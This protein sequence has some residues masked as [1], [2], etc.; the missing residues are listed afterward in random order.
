MPYAHRYKT[1]SI[2]ICSPRIYGQRTVSSALTPG[3][4]AGVLTEA[5]VVIKVVATVLV[6]MP[7][8]EVVVMVVVTP[9]NINTML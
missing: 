1:F 6:V 8:V 7:P 3:V 5:L 2:S 4:G 9:K